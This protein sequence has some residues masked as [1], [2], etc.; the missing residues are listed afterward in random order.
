M[1]AVSFLGETDGLA[2][3]G[4]GAG[5]GFGTE[6]G[7]AG[8]EGL[9]VVVSFLGW[10]LAGAAGAE[11]VGTAG[12]GGAGATGATGATGFGGAGADA[13][14]IAGAAGGLGK[15]GAEGA[16]GGRGVLNEAGL[17]GE[18][19]G[20]EGGAGMAP[21]PL[22][23]GMLMRTVSRFTGAV[24]PGPA[25]GLRGRLMRTVSFLGA[26]LDS[27][28]VLRGVFSSAMDWL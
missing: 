8:A 22:F 25:V 4:A 28:V 26:S 9:I 11:T 13:T 21:G 1:R 7:A 12:L 23:F 5:A 24:P 15:K 6:V 18:M 3:I 19:L 10:A 20:A 2:A 16:L 27:L 17:G 14:G